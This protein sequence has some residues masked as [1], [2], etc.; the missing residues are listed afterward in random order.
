MMHKS[1]GLALGA[2][3]FLAAPGASAETTIIFGHYAPVQAVSVKA[4]IKWMAA[5]EIDTA[6]RIKFKRFFGGALSRS[7]SKGPELM[8]NGIQD[9]TVVLPS[10]TAKLFPDFSLME[11]PYMFRTAEEASIAGWRFHQ[12]GLMR[13]LDKMQV[14]SVFSNGNAN[15]HFNQTIKSASGIKG[16]KIA[17]TG[18]RKA[19]IIVLLGGVP[20]SMGI[21]QVAGALNQNV[22]QGTMSGWSALT[23]FRI[24]KLIK[25]HYEE[26]FG[27]L[28]FFLPIR[29][30]L[31]DRLSRNDRQVVMKHGG[32][33]YARAMVGLWQADIDS[34]KRKAIAD[35]NRNIIGYTPAELN[36]RAAMYQRF[37]DDWIAKTPDGQK[38]YDAL[39]GILK[40][41]R[42][43]G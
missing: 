21:F 24:T 35:P 9:S 15:L 36:K 27:A 19:E 13:G 17:T 4:A 18:P 33:G 30:D 37:H 29:K 39:M 6:G 2:I 40:K 3:A 26:P 5:I 14:V 31:F 11:L 32:E 28:M 34:D 41:L 12:L 10:Y 22:I 23:P 25:T 7:P 16:K 43:S 8:M 38:K 20:V 42:G 1:I